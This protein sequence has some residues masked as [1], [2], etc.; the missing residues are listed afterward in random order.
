M[1]SIIKSIPLLLSLWAFSSSCVRVNQSGIT[2][3]SSAEKMHVKP[4]K[5]A[6]DSVTRDGNMYQVTA[7]QVRE[8]LKHKGDV[9]VYEFM[10]TCPSEKRVKP[11]ALIK[12]CRS[13]GF[14][15]CVISCTYDAVFPLSQYQCPMFVVNTNYY[16]TENMG[17]YCSKFYS[18]LC[19]KNY[20][21]IEGIYLYFHKGQYV[22]D[23]L[24]VN[25]IKA[26][27]MVMNENKP[28]VQ[29]E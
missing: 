25:E 8:Y 27:G 20:E 9:I 21:E 29:H 18:E 14:D 24:D 22:T 26:L 13:I 11:N 3:L 1:K 17:E 6:M 23:F 2:E 12:L 5:V 28:S 10:S 19:G 15:V 4:L 7:A 16:N